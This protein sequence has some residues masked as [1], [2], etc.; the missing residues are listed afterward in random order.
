M[1][2]FVSTVE[3]STIR[4]FLFGFKNPEAIEKQQLL[5]IELKSLTKKYSS[6]KATVPRVYNKKLI[7]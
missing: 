1:G 4:F 2:S 6:L 5:N 3:Y 7:F